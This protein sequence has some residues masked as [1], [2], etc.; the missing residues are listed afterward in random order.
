MAASTSQLPQQATSVG[1]LEAGDVDG[2]GDLDLLIADWG[3]G[4]P[5]TNAGGRTRTRQKKALR[6][7]GMAHADMA[8]R[9]DHALARQDAISRDKLLDQVIQF[10]HAHFLMRCWGLGARS[11][12]PRRSTPQP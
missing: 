4:N 8:E 1:D 2:D 6:V 10:G 5:A 12:H 11:I 3:T 7:V 9:V